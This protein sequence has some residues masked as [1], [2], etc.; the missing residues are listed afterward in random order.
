[1]QVRQGEEK[2]SELLQTSIPAP[3]SN[4][5]LLSIALWRMS[6]LQQEKKKPDCWSVHLIAHSFIYFWW[7][8]KQ[9]CEID[10]K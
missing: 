2:V 9:E 8:R 1:M 10:L 3:D 5:K 7:L 6:I 4:I